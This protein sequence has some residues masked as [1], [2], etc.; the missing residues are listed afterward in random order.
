MSKTDTAVSEATVYA[1]NI[2]GITE[3]EI[4]VPSGVTVLA[5]RNATN[6]TSFLQSIMAGLGSDDVT[7]KGDADEG[8]VELT[9]DGETYERTLRRS[10]GS[11]VFAAP[12]TSAIR[13]LQISSPSCSRP[14]RSVRP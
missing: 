6:R 12:P 9:I 3:T 2:G 5:G 8:R 1:E 13:R 4:D 11:I 14:T 10:N 7:L